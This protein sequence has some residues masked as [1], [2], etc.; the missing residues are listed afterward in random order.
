MVTLPNDAPV[1]VVC[2]MLYHYEYV[3]RTSASVRTDCILIVFLAAVGATSSA[4]RV[5][6]HS[7]STS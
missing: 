2:Y 3:E 7:P 4:L 5:P 1:A 6:L